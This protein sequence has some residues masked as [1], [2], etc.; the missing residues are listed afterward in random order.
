M[1]RTIPDFV[2]TAQQLIDDHM[3]ANFPNN[4]RRVLSI[5]KGGRKY[6]RIVVDDGQRSVYCFVEVKT[7][8]ILKAAGWQKPSPIVR[9]NINDAD[10]GLSAITPYGAVYHG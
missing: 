3:A 6:A 1:A 5:D 8:N 4:P 7:G 10:G 2:A 9:G